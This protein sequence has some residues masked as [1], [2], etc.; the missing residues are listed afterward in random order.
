MTTIAYRAPF[1]ACDGRVTVG[2]VIFTDRCEKIV[3]LTGGGLLGCAGAADTRAVQDLFDRVRTGRLMPA[4]KE[5]AA[6]QCDFRAILALPDGTLWCVE[7]G[8]DYLDED[9]EK[10]TGVW[11]AYVYPIHDPYF[12]VGSG[13]R[14]AKAA[15]DCGK[16]AEQAVR[17]ALKNDAGSGGRVQVFELQLRRRRKT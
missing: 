15:M 11:Y 4:A 14:F 2:N 16:S 13:S 17:L 3:R 6:L 9:G 7:S 10:H 5:I 12:A 8:P 1:M